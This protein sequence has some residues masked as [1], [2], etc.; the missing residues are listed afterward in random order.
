MARPSVALIEAFRETADR[1][2]RG[3]P[4][5]WTHMGSCNCGHLAQ[6]VTRLSKAQI[7]ALALAKSGDWT[8]Q[9]REYCPTSG[10]PFDHV[11]QS[12]LDLGLSTGDLADLEKLR[13]PK[14]RAR[15]GR[16]DADISFKD[17]AD[18]VAY[19]RAWADL[20][21]ARMPEAE[22]Q[23]P[24]GESALAPRRTPVPA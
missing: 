13:N 6:T 12:L 7:H 10:F 21:Q 23:P 22:V 11:L 14:V 5:R 18:V 24:S 3:A 9:A 19:L 4:Y 2:D 1:L 15:M 20:L 16:R 8:E 17:R